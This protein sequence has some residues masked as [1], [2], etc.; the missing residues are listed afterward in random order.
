[1]NQP[2]TSQ[3]HH[4]EIVVHQQ[5]FHGSQPVR[6]RG[7]NWRAW[8]ED[9]VALDMLR[10]DRD[11]MFRDAECSNTRGPSG[12]KRKRTR[13]D[14]CECGGGFAATFADPIRGEGATLAT[15]LVPA[16]WLPEE[17]ARELGYHGGINLDLCEPDMAAAIREG[18]PS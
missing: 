13:R 11:R 3:P 14:R 6:I 1:M 9:T 10:Q 16:T 15:M 18:I 17:F 2:A 5:G 8:N 7:M 12:R 4:R